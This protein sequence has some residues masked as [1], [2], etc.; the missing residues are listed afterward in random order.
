MEDMKDIAKLGLHSIEAIAEKFHMSEQLLTR[1]NP[2]KKFDHA[3][4]NIVVV[5]TGVG[6]GDDSVKA[7]KIEVDKTRQTVKLFDKSNAL[8]GFYPATVGSEE[9]PS[10]SG[11]LKVTGAAIRPIATSRST[12][13]R[14]CVPTS[15]SRSNRAPTTQWARYGSAYRRKDTG[16]MARPNRERS[17][18]RNRTAACVLR[19]G[20]PSA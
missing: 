12:T 15:R 2:G 1:L 13:S 10:P 17:R 11:T 4:E 8:I 18:R 3:G 16:S 9:K 14:A 7:D 19:T 5:D 20:M 6:E